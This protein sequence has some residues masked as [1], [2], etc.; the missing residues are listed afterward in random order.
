MRIVTHLAV[1]AL[2]GA[3]AA[4]AGDWPRFRGPG[5]TGVSPDKTPTP[6]KWSPTENLKWKTKLPGP[7]VSCPIVVGDK[8]FVTCYSG[9]GVGRG[10]LGSMSNLK[11][12]LV[13]VDRKSGKILWDKSV[14]AVL[15]EDPF[16]G[17]GIPQHGY[18]SHTPVSD[19]KNVYVF[20]GKS[21]ALAFDMDGNQLWQKS[22]GTGS[23]RMR[24]GSASSPVLYKNLMIVTAPAESE[25]I[26]AFDKTTGKQAW[27]Q[28][29]AGYSNLWGTPVLVK[30]DDA[31][32]DLVIGV[33]GEIWALNPETGKLRWYCE[34]VPADQFNSSVVVV[35]KT[36]YAV[37]AGARGGGGSIAVKA[38]GKGNITKSNVVWSGRQSSRFPTPVVY[39]GRLYVVASKTATCLDAKTGNQV[40]RSRLQ[41][42]NAG[43]RPR[44][45]GR[46]GGFGGGDYSSPIIA[47][48]KLYYV[49]RGGDMYVLK[50]GKTFER[51]AVNRVTTDSEDFS[52]TPA[53]SDGEL[54]IRSNRKLYC[55]A[56]K[57]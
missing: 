56:A 30:I 32:T 15:P 25:S 23:D 45:G 28:K 6:T 17:P 27:Q 41:G 37:Q 22:A 34:G 31:R 53:V 4:N 26:V 33:P 54:F 1:L 21:G 35:D 7:G 14:K 47:D 48:G 13:C 24:Y 40:F 38:G 2:L 43:G 50:A 9:Y 36:V 49:T 55:V 44:G 57:K 10:N 51:L 16:R 8:V 52:A 11:R 12:H 5:G 18:A 20:F 39:E 46:R 42:G 29:I 19:G 3:T